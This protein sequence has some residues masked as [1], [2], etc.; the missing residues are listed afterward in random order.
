MGCNN[1]IYTWTQQIY[2]R[3]ERKSQSDPR[4]DPRFP[5][6]LLPSS[7]WCL[8]MNISAGAQNM[9]NLM[10]L[11]I[12]FLTFQTLIHFGNFLSGGSTIS[13]LTVEVYF[14]QSY[15]RHN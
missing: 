2:Q 14:Y 13:C 15:Y 3:K 7:C 4:P 6:L 5:G 11:P 9:I 12:R 8:A 10:N 1:I